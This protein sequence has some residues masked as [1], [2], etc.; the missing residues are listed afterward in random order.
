[1]KRVLILPAALSSAR[2][3]LLTEDWKPSGY[4]GSTSIIHDGDSETIQAVITDP[5]RHVHSSEEIFQHFLDADQD[6][7]SDE[8][9]LEPEEPLDPATRPPKCYGMALADAPDMGPYQ[10]GALLGLLKHQAKIGEKYQVFTGVSIGALNAYIASMY[11]YEN[12]NDAAQELS[13]LTQSH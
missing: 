6:E 1:M 13:K 12:I 4:T 7:W 2:N 10:A 8:H 9:T 11:D 5:S 3:I